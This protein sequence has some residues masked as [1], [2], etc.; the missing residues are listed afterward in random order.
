VL[1][2]KDNK[3]FL[4]AKNIVLATASDGQPFARYHIHRGFVKDSKQEETGLLYT[5]TDMAMPKVSQILSSNTS[6]GGSPC[7]YVFWTS[8]TGDML[9][10]RGLLHLLAPPTSSVQSPSLTRLEALLPGFDWEAFRVRVWKKE[11][12]AHLR[13]TFLNPAPGSNWPEGGEEE[14]K[15]KLDVG[16]E[17]EERA[18]ERFAVLVV[19]PEVLDWSR[20]NEKPPVRQVFERDEAGNWLGRKVAP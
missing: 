13:A 17:G 18:L 8:P 1:G 3:E 10:Y 19:E 5:T 20:T 14:M 12:S 7:E 2:H 15:E 16:D 4:D 6:R 9:R 11:M